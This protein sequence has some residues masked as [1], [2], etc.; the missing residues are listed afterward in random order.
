MQPAESRLRVTDRAGIACPT[1][2]EMFTEGT[3]GGWPHPLPGL[4]DKYVNPQC[5]YSV[6]S[7]ACHPQPEQHQLSQVETWKSK[8][9]GDQP[10]ILV[11]Y[12]AGGPG[13]G[14]IGDIVISTQITPSLYQTRILHPYPTTNVT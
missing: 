5:V 1:K 7:G 4:A 8:L 3:V 13:A 2:G 14:S 10:A 11:R 6:S 12:A 9:T